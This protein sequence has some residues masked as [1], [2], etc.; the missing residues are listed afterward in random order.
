MD[1]VNNI[2]RAVINECHNIIFPLKKEY[3][4]ING[5]YEIYDQRYMY[6]I[7]KL[8]NYNAFSQKS[9][10]CR[11]NSSQSWK[12]K[13]VHGNDMVVLKILLNILRSHFL[14]S[15][16]VILIS[17]PNH[18]AANFVIPDISFC[19]SFSFIGLFSY[20]SR[21]FYRISSSKF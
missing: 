2:F 20:Q 14:I 11:I 7:Y 16:A 4:L 1:F 19:H 9:L 6:K 17:S 12:K 10:F 8:I 15:V 18:L 13:V 3:I 5:T 21:G